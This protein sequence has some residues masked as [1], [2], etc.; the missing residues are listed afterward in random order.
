MNYVLTNLNVL[1]DPYSLMNFNKEKKKAFQ[2]NAINEYSGN[3]SLFLH[4]DILS[5]KEG[6]IAAF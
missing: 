4:L 1:S 5:L 6:F 3:T 2:A